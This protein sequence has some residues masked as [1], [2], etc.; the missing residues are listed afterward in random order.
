MLSEADQ[1]CQPKIPHSRC[2]RGVIQALATGKTH[3]RGPRD[4]DLLGCLLTRARTTT[5]NSP[6]RQWRLGKRLRPLALS[7]SHGIALG[8][9]NRNLCT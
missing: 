6:N 7:R 3:N 4:Y 9:G 1:I 2:A 8:Y 5:S